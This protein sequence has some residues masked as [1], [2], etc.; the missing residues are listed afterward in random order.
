MGI[1]DI[2]DRLKHT[3]IVK[4]ESTGHEK[5]AHEEQERKYQEKSKW[6]SSHNQDKPKEES[7]KEKV[8]KSV[9]SHGKKFVE[10]SRQRA[11]E[12]ALR[13]SK[14][15][16]KPKKQAKRQ[17]DTPRPQNQFSF[18]FGN[19]ENFGYDMFSNKKKSDSK[20][21][22]KQQGFHFGFGNSEIPLDEM[23]D[24]RVKKKKSSIDSVWN[25][26]DFWQ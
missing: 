8:L 23:F 6:H 4:A 21:E 3:R 26:R 16:K 5:K 17:D 10:K 2:A 22:P 14:K 9:M 13:Q 12:E 20:E 11:K 24:F 1:R 15:S 19:M 7:A 18:G 25:P